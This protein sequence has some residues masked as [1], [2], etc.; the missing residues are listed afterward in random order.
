MFAETL[1]GLALVK[2]AVSNIKEV[3]DTCND[4]G[5]ITEHIDNLFKGEQQAQKARAKK[6]GFSNFDTENVAQEII[7]AKIAQEKLQEIATL[8][9]WRF[10][11]GTWASILAER[12]RR[13]DQ[14]KEAEK[15]RL[16][17]R[18]ARAQEIVE[19]VKLIGI[20]IGSAIALFGLFL[21]YIFFTRR[22]V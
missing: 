11:H 4:I 3:I 19:N 21:L 12:K 2:H 7:D 1:A 5:D 6:S 18:R 13:I 15:H 16:Q 22:T 20:I 10:G 8:V 9:D 14:A 17:E